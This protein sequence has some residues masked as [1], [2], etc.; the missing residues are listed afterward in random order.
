MAYK[1]GREKHTGKYNFQ[2]VK[3]WKNQNNFE[4]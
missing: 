1:I 2:A 3:M 4:F